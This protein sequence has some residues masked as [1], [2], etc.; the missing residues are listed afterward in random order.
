MDKRALRKFAGAGRKLNLRS[1]IFLAEQVKYIVCTAIHNIAGRRTLVLYVYSKETMSAG[2]LS[3]RW[4]V[5]QTADE[6]ITLGCDEKGMHWQTSMFESLGKKYYF[7]DKC[8]FYSLADEQRVSRF[9]KIPNK[10]GV[11]ALSELQRRLFRKRQ[12]ESRR[13]REQKIVDKMKCVGAL[14]RDI[15]GFMRRETLPQ[16]LFYDYEKRKAVGGYCTACKHEVEVKDARH[17]AKGVCPR[18][19]KAIIFKSRGKRGYIVDRSTAQVIERTGENEIVV[20]FVK[21]YC[22][23]PKR[24]APEFSV[25]ENARLFL[26]WENGKIVEAQP[27]YWSYTRGGLTPWQ[28]GDRPVF[29]R[30]QYNF[31]ADSCGYLYHRNLDDTLKGTPFQYSA[32]KEYYFADPTPLYVPRYL[33]EYLRYPMLEYLVKLRLYRLATYVVYGENGQQ[34]YGNQVL[35]GNGRTITEVLGVSK[36][37]LPLLQEV[38]PGGLQLKLVKDLLREHIQPD[39]G[40]LKWCS[41]NGVG[42]RDSLTIPLRFMTAHKL[43]R[44]ATE[45]FET[46]R[47][48]S[49]TSP[50]YYSMPNLLSDYA[51]YLS[52]SEALDYDMKNSFV[53]FPRELKEAHDRV[54]DLSDTELSE[55]YDRKVAKDFKDLQ[56]KYQFAGLGL[57]VV[58]PHSAKEIVAEGQ[59]L[60][61]CV[62][63]YVKDVVLGKCVILFI[64]RS[65]APDEPFCTVELKDG[66]VTQAR[67]YDNGNPP[68]RVQKF[69]ELWKQQVLY[70]PADA[71]A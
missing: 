68:P 1:G 14:P 34:F 8:A 32:L 51:D 26:R 36:R 2:D 44:Y 38:N 10:K 59:K 64:R 29:S 45:Q 35:N 22:R 30:W 47:K 69:M 16:Y 13:K 61:H 65:D 70:T 28:K 52:M 71:A 12:N 17:N 20:R 54:N 50:G 63:R 60:H 23:Y 7:I 42:N 43:M 41:E 25:Y 66:T 39:V 53:L 4:T 57:V 15:K 49:Y 31:E 3:P 37:Y 18:C 48:T 6:Y 19:K 24:D 46:H 56:G 33:K 55:A 67:I 27:Y 40:L 21:A 5:F 9:C 58:P 62:G 11:Y